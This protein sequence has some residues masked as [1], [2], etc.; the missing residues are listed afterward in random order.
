[1]TQ[2]AFLFSPDQ[3]GS[4]YAVRCR[5]CGRYEKLQVER[6]SGVICSRADYWPVFQVSS[7]RCEFCG[8]PIPGNRNLRI[9]EACRRSSLLAFRKKAKRLAKTESMKT[10]NLED[11]DAEIQQ[12]EALNESKAPRRPQ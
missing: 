9:C 8:G 1:L 12:G 7:T 4:I 10:K 6:A 3:V 5:L 2:I 11:A